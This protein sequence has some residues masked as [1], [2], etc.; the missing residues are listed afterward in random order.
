MLK[1]ILRSIYLK[2][3]KKIMRNR[4]S[5]IFEVTLTLLHVIFLFL[6]YSLKFNFSWYETEE[7]YSVVQNIFM[8]LFSNFHYL[9]YTVTAQKWSPSSNNIC[10]NPLKSNH[11][12]WPN[13]LKRF[14]G[15]SRRNS[16]IVFDHFVGL[17]LKG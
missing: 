3:F 4:K 2:N 12:N 14:V 6:E 1:N 9:K 10:L 15:N 8:F 17:A 5:F 13:K 16:L 11:T 7:S